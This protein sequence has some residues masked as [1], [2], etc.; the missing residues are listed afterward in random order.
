MKKDWK[1]KIFKNKFDT[2]T[3]DSRNPAV[4]ARLT[5]ALEFL[6]TN[7]TFKNKSICD[8][9]AGKGEFIE[10][11]RQADLQLKEIYGVELS[12]ENSEILKKKNINHFTGGVEEYWKS[13]TYK[14]FDILTLNW[15]LENTQSAKHCLDICYDLLKD[16]GVILIATGSRIL[17]PFKKPL[18]NYIPKKTN[19]D[20]HPFHFSANSIK[21]LLNNAGFKSLI[22]N[23]YIDTD[24]LCVIGRKKGKKPKKIKFCDDPKEIKF[25]FSRWHNESLNYQ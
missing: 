12:E 23:R 2:S 17:V 7:I 18:Q 22:Y 20:I 3:Y 14:K 19:L 11:L 15:T 1:E 10:F 13:K 5:Y 24:Y 16:D 4:F 25:F 21:A 8:V 6:K 9:G